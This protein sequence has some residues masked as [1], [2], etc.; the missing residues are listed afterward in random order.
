[1]KLLTLQPLETDRS[2]QWLLVVESKPS[3]VKGTVWWDG[4]LSNQT[5][6]Y[7]KIIIIIVSNGN[8][9]SESHTLTTIRIKSKFH[10]KE[11]SLHIPSPL[12]N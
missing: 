11:I 5:G 10:G 4:N 8:R 1:M 12:C 2:S 9:V 3:R 7:L 6:Q